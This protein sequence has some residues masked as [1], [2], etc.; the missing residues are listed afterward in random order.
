MKR[1]IPDSVLYPVMRFILRAVFR[2]RV[3]GLEH[4]PRSG[5]TA[6]DREPHLVARRGPPRRVPAG[7]ARLC[8]AH[9]DR[10]AAVGEALPEARHGLPDRPDSAD[11]PED[12]LRLRGGGRAVVIFPEGRLSTTGAS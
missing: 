11:A 7:Q 12:A 6:R 2:V 3:R 9:A 1:L 5:R 4:Y 10:A 8:R